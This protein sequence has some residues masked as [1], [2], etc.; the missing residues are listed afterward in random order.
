[1]SNFLGWAYAWPMDRRILYN[2]AG[3]DLNGKPWSKDRVGIQ[4]DAIQGKWVGYDVPD[5]AATKGPDDPTFNDP[6]IMQESGK[7]DLFSAKMNEGPFPE[8][9]EPWEFPLENQISNTQFN[10]AVQFGEK[11]LEAKG[12]FEKFPII[13]TTYRVS[14][15][16]QTG[17]MTEMFLGLLNLFHICLLKSVKSWQKKEALK[18]K[19]ES[20][21]LVH[22]EKL[23]PMQWLQNALNHT[24]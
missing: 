4:W 17:W 9:Y 6:F 12:E 16:W 8:H 1:M 5:F 18:T 7:G 2:R 14:E 21:F 15:H 24:N 13:A 3:A 10:P 20:L 22:V 11:K 23:R 19:I